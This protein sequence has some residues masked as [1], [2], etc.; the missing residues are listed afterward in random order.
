[1]S[2]FVDEKNKLVVQGAI[3]D[4]ADHVVV[5]RPITQAPDPIAVIEKM[6]EGIARMV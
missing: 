4:G 2:I 1:M 5:G 3:G 6:Q